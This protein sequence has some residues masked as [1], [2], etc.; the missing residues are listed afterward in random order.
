[1]SDLIDKEH[2]VASKHPVA[3]PVIMVVGL[4]IIVI[5]ILSY[6]LYQTVAENT[7]LKQ[8][9]QENTEGPEGYENVQEQQL[10]NELDQL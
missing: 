7:R 10:E 9:Y 8:N 3:F 4:M 6:F 5:A 1:M 2:K